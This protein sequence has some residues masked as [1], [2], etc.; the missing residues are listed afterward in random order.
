MERRARSDHLP[1]TPKSRYSLPVIKMAPDRAGMAAGL[2]S[3]AS[4]CA[5]GLV[6]EIE[7]LDNGPWAVQSMHVT[8]CLIALLGVTR[9]VDRIFFK[10]RNQLVWGDR[11]LAQQPGLILGFPLIPYMPTNELSVS[12]FH[13]LRTD[14]AMAACRGD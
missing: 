8:P 12:Y 7:P 4:G 6:W 2:E 1:A 10:I 13:Y 3:W 5:L 9:D 14:S 11:H